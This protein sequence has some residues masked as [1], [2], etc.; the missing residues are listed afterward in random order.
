MM[1]TQDLLGRFDDLLS[2]I[3]STW[4][5]LLIVTGDININLLDQADNITRQYMDILQGLNLT[6]HVTKPTRTT[7]TSKSLID[8]LIS[9]SP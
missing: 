1:N 6:N 4:D 9:N 7:P 2:N 5:G 3:M 8:H